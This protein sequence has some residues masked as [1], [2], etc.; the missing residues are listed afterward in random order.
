VFEWVSGRWNDFMYDISIIRVIVLMSARRYRNAFEILSSIQGHRGPSSKRE[1]LL[2]GI[3]LLEMGDPQ[4]AV[5]LLQRACD[6]DPSSSLAREKLCE[7]QTKCKEI[8]EIPRD[9]EE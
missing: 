9:S 8:P 5:V 1:D 2:E 6:S 4:Q 3:L 7:A